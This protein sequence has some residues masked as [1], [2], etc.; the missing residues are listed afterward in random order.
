MCLCEVEKKVQQEG[1]KKQ[2]NLV[3]KYLVG[4]KKGFLMSKRKY[5]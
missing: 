2:V 4:K 1:M 3:L 5:I